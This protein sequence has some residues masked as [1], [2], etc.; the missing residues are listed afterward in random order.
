[1]VVMS[2]PGVCV[3]DSSLYN[4]FKVYIL[5]IAYSIAKLDAFIYL[6]LLYRNIFGTKLSFIP[7]TYEICLEFYLLCV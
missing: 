1:M 3:N 2:L 6:L 5:V 4:L 7:F